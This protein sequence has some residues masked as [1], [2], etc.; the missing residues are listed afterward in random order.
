MNWFTIRLPIP[1]EDAYLG[2]F[3]FESV[4]WPIMSYLL[5]YQ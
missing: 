4:H 1:K 3:R 2:L 5:M